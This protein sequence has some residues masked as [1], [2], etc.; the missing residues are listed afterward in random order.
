M[1]VRGLGT[2]WGCGGWLSTT[3]RLAGYRALLHMAS[4]SGRREAVGVG[5]RPQMGGGRNRRS[6]KTTAARDSGDGPGKCKRKAVTDAKAGAKAEA[7]DNGG[8]TS[9][10]RAAMALN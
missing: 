10:S 2:S 8:G 6:A 1:S 9:S 7:N 4:V 3:S 5:G